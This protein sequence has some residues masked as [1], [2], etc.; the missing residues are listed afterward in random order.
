MNSNLLATLVAPILGLALTLVVVRPFI[1]K[2]ASIA[3]LEPILLVTFL[4]VVTIWLVVPLGALRGW[5]P[6]FLAYGL[7]L[8]SLVPYLVMS[9]SMLVWE[10]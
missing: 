9:L 10:D 8:G 5:W 1:P 7:C 3:D 4:T 6:S 2:N